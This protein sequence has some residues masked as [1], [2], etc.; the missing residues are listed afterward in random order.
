VG[1]RYAHARR[2]LERLLAHTPNSNDARVA[3]ANI[4]WWNGEYTELERLA[5]AGRLQW[6]DAIE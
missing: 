1:G 2:E 3:L 4:A 6:P 5:G